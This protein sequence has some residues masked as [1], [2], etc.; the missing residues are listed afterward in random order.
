MNFDTQ[1][2]NIGRGSLTSVNRREAHT[3][4]DSETIEE[5]EKPAERN[6]GSSGNR[7]N[8]MQGCKE[9]PESKTPDAGFPSSS[10]SPASTHALGERGRIRQCLFGATVSRRMLLISS[11]FSFFFS[12]MS[13]FFFLQVSASQDHNQRPCLAFVLCH[14]LDAMCGYILT[15]IIQMSFPSTMEFRNIIL[16]VSSNT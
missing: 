7:S 1:S 2:H 11:F 5:P 16:S 8:N 14:A 10:H 6:G 12:E 3:R 15:E 13:S 9:M 4:T